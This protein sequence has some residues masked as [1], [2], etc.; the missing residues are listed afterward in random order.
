VS[1]AVVASAV[2]VALGFK[3]GDPIIGLTITLVI[4]RIK[5]QSI[6]TIKADPGV[7]EPVEHAHG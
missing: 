3:L 1:L 4:L 2:V 7:P 5:W 6:Q